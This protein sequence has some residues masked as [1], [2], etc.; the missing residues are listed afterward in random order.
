M[1]SPTQAI[2]PAHA[3]DAAA[4]THILAT[5]FREDP[6]LAWILTDRAD[7]E[8]LSPVFFQP[9]V[10]MVL[11]DGHGYIAED[12]SGAALWLDVDVHAETTEDSGELREPTT[13]RGTSEAEVQPDEFRQ[14]FIDG[15]GSE[16]AK[17]F[18]ILDELFSGSHPGHES[19][20]YLLF[21]GV[22]PDRQ[23][24]GVGTA[25]LNAGLGPVDQAIRPAYVEA[26]T[27]RN[28]AL[29]ARHGFESMGEPIAL[30]DGP[31]LYPMW[32]PPAGS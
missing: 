25:L 17:R 27:K 22:V 19:H 5:G 14:R 16:Y 23:C 24:Q 29:Y 21:I 9:F 6:P 26:S 13:E 32:R 18:F 15:L 31:S 10:D 28:A 3:G 12:L 4:I 11:T 1:T 7:R 8:R 20:A 2:R 30:P